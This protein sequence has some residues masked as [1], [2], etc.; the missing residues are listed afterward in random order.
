MNY[1]ATALTILEALYQN[2][3]NIC[4]EIEKFQP[5]MVIGLAHSGWMPVVVAQT[6]WAQTRKGS[7]PPAMRTNIGREKHEF[8]SAR[9]GKS[10]PAFCCW[11]CSDS[12]DRAGH[13]LAWVAEQD[14]WLATLRAQIEQVYSGIP[15]RILVVDDLFGG[16]RSGYMV[17][18]LLYSLYPQVATYVMAGHT[19]L[20]DNFV[21]AW[22]E[23]FIPVLV[24]DGDE[25]PK[26]SQRYSSPWQELLKPLITET[27]D[28]SLDRLDWHLLSPE[29]PAVR[30]LIEYLPLETIL[31]A[32]T[33]ARE[34]ARCYAL[35][36]LRGEFSGDVPVLPED[37]FHMLPV[38]RLTLSPEYRLAARA[39]QR[40]EVAWA[41]I[42]EFFGVSLSGKKKGLKA[43]S[44]GEDWFRRGPRKDAI[45]LPFLAAYSWMTAYDPYRA[46]LTD[47]GKAVYCFA[48]FL[49]GQL[50]AGAYPKASDDDVKDQPF[51]DF[52]ALG[53]D[54]FI[55]LVDAEDITHKWPYERALRKISKE[56][57]KKVNIQSLPLP[58]RAGPT[59]A[60]MVLL[61]KK[62]TRA[63]KAGHRIY[64]HAGHNLD[65]RTPLVLTCLL[66]LQGQSPDQALARVNSFWLETLPFLLHL[67][68]AEAQQKFITEWAEYCV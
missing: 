33:W 55:S 61:L 49:P 38:V 68:L 21:T 67:P 35:E 42:V 41:D 19:D 47:P 37:E 34:L 31:A 23:E 43:V 20:T 54:S 40:N 60:E 25:K 46:E 17:M 56:S 63:L 26:R 58:Y 65:G 36:R 44:N 4:V 50:W 10:I 45:Y 6:L 53:I 27:E 14:A 48:E 15:A 64:L 28:I 32:P 62:L 57:T 22:L 7:F 2:G 13:Y 66:I 16:A 8:Y 39:W 51:K 18:A 5:D 3:T 52:L 12:P 29:S 24:R 1:P 9:F 59:L 30:A 11:T